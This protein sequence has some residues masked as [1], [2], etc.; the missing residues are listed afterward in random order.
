M[1]LSVKKG[2]LEEC[3]GSKVSDIELRRAIWGPFYYIAQMTGL[4]LHTTP[5]DMK[6][7]KG[8]LHLI[9]N[10]LATVILLAN[11]VYTVV[12]MNGKSF[13]I[14]WSYSISLMFFA[15][16]G[17]VSSLV[18]MG[19]KFDNYFSNVVTL[20][21]NA[22]RNNFSITSFPPGIK[23][24]FIMRTIWFTVVV[25]SM[26]IYCVDNFVLYSK[27]VEVTEPENVSNTDLQYFRRSMFGY[28]PLFCLDTIIKIY[29]ILVSASCLLIYNCAN[30]ACCSEFSQFNV[31]LKEKITDKSIMK[32]EVVEALESQLTDFLK[33]IK[34]ITESAVGSITI[35]FISGV[36]ILITSMYAMRAFQEYLFF[37]IVT[38]GFWIATSVIF[39]FYSTWRVGSFHQLMMET[40]DFLNLSHEIQK[41]I[42]D[43]KIKQI[44]RDMIYRINNFNYGSKNMFSVRSGT[45][46]FNLLILIIPFVSDFLVGVKYVPEFIISMTNT[47]S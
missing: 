18:M 34:Y 3:D 21:R 44:F 27:T 42:Q 5:E 22:T 8:L 36:M 1:T 40:N 29:S 39:L 4:I 12:M 11:A 46:L 47:T 24:K 7:R 37:G 16:N 25:I 17:T 45:A 43:E 41:E 26:P 10:V 38:I 2:F 19:Y 33:L 28:Q 31:H 13:S 23:F 14:N 30:G 20:L 15:I 9:P 35:G 32:V 6:T